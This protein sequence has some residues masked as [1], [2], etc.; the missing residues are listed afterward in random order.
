MTT[1]PTNN[2]VPSESP[3]DLKFNAGKIDEFVTSAENLYTDRFGEEHYTIE[4]LRWLAQQAIAQYGYIT[5]DSFQGGANITLPN[6]VLRDTT[7]GEYYRWDGAL[8]KNV[9]ENSTPL[10]TGGIGV[11][12]WLSVGDAVLRGNLSS[13]ANGLGDALISVKQPFTDSTVRTQHEKNTEFITPADFTSF[14]GALAA[15]IANNTPLFNNDTAFMLTVGT[16]GEFS[17]LIE[18]IKAAC[19]MRPTWKNGN[20][21]C[22]IKLKS[23]YVL[24]EQF[25][26]G[27]GID[28]S[29]IKITSEDVVVYASTAAF[30]ETVRTYYLNKYMFYFYD[31]AKSPIFAIQIEENRSNSDVT[32][33][34]A[35]QNAV[36]NFYAYS[37]ARKF[38]I[39]VDASYGALLNAYHTGCAPDPDAVAAYKPPGY[40]VCDF[41]YSRQFALLA[42]SAYVNMPLSK[43][44]YVTEKKQASVTAIYNTI[45]NFQG[46]SASYSYIGWN[47]R[48]GA[49]VNIRDHKTINCPYRGLTM[50]HT[51]YVDARRHDVEEQDVE[52]SGQVLRPELQQ[53]F[54]GCALGV[55][56]DGAGCVD[57]SGNDMRNCGITINADNGFSVSAKGLDV[58]NCTGMVFSCQ[59]GS[60]YASRVWALSVAKY[61]RLR[62]G[63]KVYGRWQTI[64]TNSTFEQDTRFFDV[65]YD[66]CVSLHESK[67]TGD[68]SLFS[69]NGSTLKLIN[70]TL[71]VRAFRAFTGANINVAGSTY[72]PA[73]AKAISPSEY[74]FRISQGG[75]INMNPMITTDGSAPVLFKP[76]N[77]ISESGIIFAGD[78]TT[79]T[80]DVVMLG[81]SLT[82]RGR[83]DVFFPLSDIGNYGIGG[84]TTQNIIDRLDA[85]LATKAKK[86]F[87]MAG[88]ND[89]AHSVPVENIMSNLIYIADAIAG[90]GI[91][92]IVQ[93]TV[94]AGRNSVSRNPRINSINSSLESQVV[95]KGYVYINLN[96]ALAPGG[97]LS[98][99]HT[100]DGI[101]LTD[102]GY[103]AWVSV[104]SSYI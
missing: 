22:E 104:V 102:A 75:T 35:T 12:A 69:G 15:A 64:T 6:Q 36:I 37:G 41:S 27:A 79:T 33:F 57:L 31:G 39:G 10:N 82:A 50:I 32:C 46:S 81:D 91:T 99:E 23:G 7:T 71:K 72:D 96:A 94:L 44:E 68:V 84:N 59:G 100:N 20:D 95:A 93:S 74:Q 45:A 34:L 40:Y 3:R 83:W 80:Y 60:V 97:A 17:S 65:D 54:Y 55:R 28:L 11:G 77:T 89:I 78:N 61:G 63:S 38:N 92:P 2:A 48:D 98:D 26:F 16:D 52:T 101:H 56:G 73:F 21:F 47:V 25:K 43:F 51:A 88:T 67:V 103:A 5:V 86:V 1:Q 58:S 42:T 90:A 70:S 9:P 85:V 49:H 87:L 29:W 19:K 13:P 8:P 62:Y 14:S 30:T 4:G 66:G 76:R 53:G 18:A 24:S